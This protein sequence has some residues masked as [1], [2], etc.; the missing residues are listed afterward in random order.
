MGIFGLG[1]KEVIYFPGCYSSAFLPDKIDNYKRIFKKIGVSVDNVR[2]LVCCGG[3]LEEAGYERQLRKLG[4]D[5]VKLLKELSVKKI[6]T[7]CPLCF[8]ILKNAYKELS[9]EWEG[10][11]V[12]SSLSIILEKIRENPN[13]LV[14]Y[15]SEEMAYYDS[16]YL[17]RYCGVTKEPRE[18][19]KLIGYR[20]KEIYNSPEETSCCGSCGCLEITHPEN[21]E[22]LG[23]R[24][25]EKVR[26]LKLKRIV[27]ADPRA[28]KFLRE[29]VEKKKMDL[30][31]YEISELICDGLGIKHE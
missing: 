24:F 31:V 23:I 21:A 10:V 6:I 18:I 5:N 19:L 16:C 22:R 28:Y 8:F 1:K 13:M 29:L 27:T 26:K 11:S 25:L 20:L 2:D 7:S 30:K 4:R 17:S 15:N 3:F 12:Y 9:P 14:S